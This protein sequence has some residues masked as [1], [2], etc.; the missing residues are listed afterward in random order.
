MRIECCTVLWARGSADGRVGQH[1]RAHTHTYCGKTSLRAGAR[2]N[3]ET[4]KSTYYTNFKGQH[5]TR[6]RRIR[7]WSRCFFFF[8]FRSYRSAPPFVVFADGKKEIRLFSHRT[9]SSVGDGRRLY[10]ARSPNTTRYC[11]PDPSSAPIPPLPFLRTRGFFF[12]LLRC[13]RPSFN[14]PPPGR[15]SASEKQK[16]RGFSPQRNGFL[17]PKL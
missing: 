14:A 6:V 4:A 3:G 7:P 16:S 13:T 9:P 10:A 17:K 8:S 2:F 5:K 1:T 12:I 15:V 11:V